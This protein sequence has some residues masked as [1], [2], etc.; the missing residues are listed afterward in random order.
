[1]GK[2]PLLK[3]DR[4][5]FKSRFWAQPFVRAWAHHFISGGL[6]ILRKWGQSSL[7][8]KDAIKIRKTA[9]E[10]P[11]EFLTNS[12]FLPGTRSYN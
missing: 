7:P 3:P 8:S 1:M 11:G 5:R 4:G 12:K 9:C 6:S 10:V 2:A